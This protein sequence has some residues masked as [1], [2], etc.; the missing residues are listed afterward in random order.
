MKQFWVYILA[1]KKYGTL[2]TGVTNNIVRR[3]WEHRE[4]LLDGF[5]KRYG[6]KQLVYYEAFDDIT[7][8]VHREKC[9]KKWR[10]DWKFE[11]VE[12]MNPDWRDLYETL[13]A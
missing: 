12:A 11:L 10:R 5:S 4:G 8:A 1:S 9:I 3:T 2:Y 13:N 6:V 7:E